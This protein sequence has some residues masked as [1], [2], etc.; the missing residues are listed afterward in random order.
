MV[1]LQRP[2][3]PE[4]LP[5]FFGGGGLCTLHL[6]AGYPSGMFISLSHYFTIVDDYVRATS[7]NK[8]LLQ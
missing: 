1:A 5:F 6:P 2:L 7:R 4:P 3:P 8:V